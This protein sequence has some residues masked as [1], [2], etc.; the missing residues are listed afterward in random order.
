MH[1]WDEKASPTDLLAGSRVEASLPLRSA[2]GDFEYRQRA[3]ADAEGRFELT[4]PYATRGAPHGLAAADHY[5]IESDGARVALA[6]DESDVR[7]GAR[8]AVPPPGDG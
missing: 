7:A 1:P 5:R 2:G 8:L 3:L 4:L 6:V